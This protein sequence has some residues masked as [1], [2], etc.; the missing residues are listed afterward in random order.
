MADDEHGPTRRQRAGRAA[1]HEAPLAGRELEVE[2]ADEVEGADGRRPV[3]EVGEDP[4]DVDVAVR[5]TSARLRER[6]LRVVDRGDPPAALGEPDRVAPSAAGEVERASRGQ[7]GDLLDEEAVRLRAR[8]GA[9][10]APLLVPAVALHVASWQTPGR[11]ETVLARVEEAD[12]V[13]V[14]VT[15]PGLAP[16]PALVDG[17]VLERVARPFQRG[18]SGV[19]I[20]ALEVDGRR[21]PLRQRTVGE[22]DR[23][24]RVAVRAGEARVAVVSPHDLLEPEAAVELDGARDV[25][26]LERDLVEPHRSD[27]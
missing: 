4:V 7:L 11:V 27:E 3:C 13:P 24:R 12:H 17:A 5:R 23:E 1:E 25:R 22:L 26:D 19:E 14:R 9:A 20:V 2:D 16:E 18:D 6:D 21:R 10:L 15:E 8:S